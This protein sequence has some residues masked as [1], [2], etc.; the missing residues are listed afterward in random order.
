LSTTIAVSVF[1]ALA[2]V[3]LAA[4]NGRSPRLYALAKPATTISLFLVTGWPGADFSI[5]VV[6]ALVFSLFGDIA[7]LRIDSTRHFLAGVGFFFVAHVALTYAFLFGGGAGWAVG[8]GVAG[9]LALG[10]SLATLRHIW[11]HVAVRMRV[12]FLIYGAAITIMFS[13]A[14]AVY[15]GPWS[16]DLR[17]AVLAGAILFYLGDMTLALNQ[18]GTPL[19][20]G[21]TISM[22]L[23]WSGQLA[24]ALAARWVDAGILS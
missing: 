14:C 23:Y 10:V 20:Q 9:L 11:P 18:F 13:S 2:L 21:Q 24:F 16:A 5:A 6:V 4:T 15:A 17:S 19:P 8:V 1:A 7:L 22:A 3:A 12:P